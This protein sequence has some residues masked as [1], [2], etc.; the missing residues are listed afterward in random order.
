MSS[1]IFWLEM[2]REEA[3]VKK[4][5][6]KTL[7][8]VFKVIVQQPIIY[9]TIFHFLIYF[10]YLRNPNKMAKIETKRIAQ[11]DVSAKKTANWET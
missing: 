4:K 7:I 11:C 6:Q 2:P 9:C 5:F 1:E 8:L 3:W 10:A